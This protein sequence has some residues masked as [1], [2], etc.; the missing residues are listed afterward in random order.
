MYFLHTPYFWTVDYLHY[1]L[2]KGSRK[3][4]ISYLKKLYE[5]YIIVISYSPR[6]QTN[7][8]RLELDTQFWLG[9]NMHL[10]F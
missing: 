4:T 3:H 5:Y 7:R 10:L 9:L 8:R 6:N 1:H 2:R